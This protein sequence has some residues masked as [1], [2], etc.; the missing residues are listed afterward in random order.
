VAENETYKEVSNAYFKLRSDEEIIEKILKEFDLTG[1]NHHIINGHT[2]VKAKNGE[3]A[4]KANG[5]LFVIDGGM[6]RAYQKKTGIA[7]YSLLYNSYGF[8]LVTHQPFA[9]VDVMLEEGIDATELREV[10]SGEMPRQF[11]RETTIG[12]ELSKEI[13][14]L[15]NLLKKVL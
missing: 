9:G 13:D 14:E 3:T 6:S 1:E 15:E 12:C 8:Q 4:I 10:V 5:K 11:I 7:G 2:P